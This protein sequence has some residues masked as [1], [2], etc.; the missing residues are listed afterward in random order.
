MSVWL[1]DVAP[2]IYSRVQHSRYS[3]INIY[4]RKAA[5]VCKDLRAPNGKNDVLGD[6]K[7]KASMQDDTPHSGNPEKVKMAKVH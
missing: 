5:N 3:R 4:Q 2:S 7:L 1:T 6:W